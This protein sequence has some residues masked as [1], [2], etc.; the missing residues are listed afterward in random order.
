MNDT[1]QKKERT[2]EW[3]P[4]RRQGNTEWFFRSM[5]RYVLG[6]GVIV[7]ELAVD[8]GHNLAV[9]LVGALLV[10]SMDVRSLVRGLIK[11]ARFERKSLEDMV[12]E[13]VRREDER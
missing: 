3:Y 4:S 12:T 10:T 8:R 9:L 6:P 2:P 13:E 1:G 5:V 11:E 7:W